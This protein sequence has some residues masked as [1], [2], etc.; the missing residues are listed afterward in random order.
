M[1]TLVLLILI[2]LICWSLLAGRPV[3]GPGNV[4]ELLLV[5]LLIVLIIW[6]AGGIGEA[7]WL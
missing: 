2:V 3:L 6:V 4:S 5:I 7:R 1:I